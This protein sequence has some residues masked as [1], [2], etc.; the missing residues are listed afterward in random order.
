MRRVAHIP[1]CLLAG[2]VFAAPGTAGPMRGFDP[3]L[4]ALTWA[5]PAVVEDEEGEWPRPYPA[6]TPTHQTQIVEDLH[7]L[8]ADRGT[9]PTLRRAAQAALNS[10][11]H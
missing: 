9:P 2:L 11:A 1:S 7:V 8:A 6:L 4:E 3:A 5:G 10:T